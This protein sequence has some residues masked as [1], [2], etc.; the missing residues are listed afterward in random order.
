MEN[1]ENKENKEIKE[2]QGENDMIGLLIGVGLG[3]AAG[4]YADRNYL[5][6][7]SKYSDADYDALK[8]EIEKLRKLA[9][10]LKKENEALI[11]AKEKNKQSSRSLEDNIEDL[12]DELA[13]TKQ[14][15]KKAEREISDYKTKI[16]DLTARIGTLEAELNEKGK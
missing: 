9:D 3:A 14:K 7:K 2:N 5:Q 4:V 8:L 1:K 6:P 16:F 11:S 15:L 13:A 10:E 12:E